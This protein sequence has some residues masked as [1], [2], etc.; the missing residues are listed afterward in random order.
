VSSAARHS[1]ADATLTITG[2][3]ADALTISGNDS[4]Q[5]V[6]TG[7]AAVT[8]SDVT[9]A[10]GRT[11]LSAGAIRNGGP[12]TL[13]RTTVRDSVAGLAGG[14]IFASGPLTLLESRVIGNTA[15]D[16]VVIVVEDVT[17][18]ALTGV[19]G[20]VT[21]EQT[22]PAGAVVAV[23]LPSATDNCG[24]VV[25]TADTPSIFPPGTTTV[26]FTATD[27]AGNA[28]TATT[29][30]TVVDTTPPAITSA[31]ASP[32]SLWPPNHRMVPVTIGLVVTDA[33]APAPTCQAAS[34]TSNEAVD[35]RGSGHTSPDW[36]V[37]GDL[38][39][40]LRAERSGRGSGRVYTVVVQCTDAAGNVATTSVPVSV[41]HD[42]GR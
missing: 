34:V 24:S 41:A 2:L 13:L 31:A 10:D 20:P 27:D 38:S 12:L 25:L 5:V 22:S 21:A 14:G 39:L 17:P 11:A 40:A 42:R 30:V 23:P 32:G 18:P 36:I 33:A 16:D 3:G 15:T 4:S 29:T 8:I 26:T 9:I 28:T 19:P 7:A 35:A 1:T 6:L 37:D